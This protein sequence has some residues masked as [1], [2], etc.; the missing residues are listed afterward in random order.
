MI[1]KRFKLLALF[2][3]VLVIIVGFSFLLIPEPKII[4]E[5]IKPNI[6]CYGGG[7]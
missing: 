6:I 5:T 3:L 2:I 1:S 4:V 7:C